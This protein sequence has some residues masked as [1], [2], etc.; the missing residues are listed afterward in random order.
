M[1]LLF[2]RFQLGATVGAA[3]ATFNGL[4][5]NVKMKMTIGKWLIPKLTMLTLGVHCEPLNSNYALKEHQHH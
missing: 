4:D 2:Q 5:F 3:A 1:G